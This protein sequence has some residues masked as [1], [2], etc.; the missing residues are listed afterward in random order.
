M[1]HNNPSVWGSR[2]WRKFHSKALYY[3]DNPT[4]QNSH[5][6]K[7]F[8][9]RDF[10]NDIQCDTC[11]SSYGQ[12]IRQHP[13]R[14]SSRMDLFNWTIDI[15]NMVNKKL[16]KKQLTYNEAYA[17]WLGSPI[18]SRIQPVSNYPNPY[19]NIDPYQYMPS[20]PNISSAIPASPI[21][22]V[23]PTNNIYGAAQKPTIGYPGAYPVKYIPIQNYPYQ[24]MAVQSVS[25]DTVR[26][27]IDRTK[28]MIRHNVPRQR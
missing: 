24:Q 17:I 23:P 14:L 22:L 13:I 28:Q 27:N 10:F 15:H 2:A 9:E 5:E 19:G 3:V 18:N 20:V 21:P 7:I 26:Q 6:V 8:Y 12:F 4:P 25:T 16:G 1:D 11:R